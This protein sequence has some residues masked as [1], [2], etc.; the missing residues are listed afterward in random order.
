MIHVVV[1]FNYTSNEEFQ[2]AQIPPTKCVFLS[3]DSGDE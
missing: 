3:K 2:D 1:L